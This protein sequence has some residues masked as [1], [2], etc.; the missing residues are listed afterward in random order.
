MTGIAIGKGGGRKGLRSATT[1]HH[2]S[3]V[4]GVAGLL[5]TVLVRS[6]KQRLRLS[7]WPLVFVAMADGLSRPLAK[8]KAIFAR[9]RAKRLI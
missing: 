8:N 5:L 3:G 7:L 2:G 9:L 4:A 6:F 1:G